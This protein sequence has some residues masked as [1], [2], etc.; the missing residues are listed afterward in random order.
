MSAAKRPNKSIDTDVLSAAFARLLAAGHLRRLALN[1]A[2]AYNG[3]MSTLFDELQ[4]QARALTPKE[5]AALAR[6][7]IDELDTAVDPGVEQLWIEEAQRRYDAFLR[8]ELTAIPG[9]EVM[10]RARSRLR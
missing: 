3:R 1:G 7:L 6:I 8:G 5:K 9:D 2:R 4:K 10:A